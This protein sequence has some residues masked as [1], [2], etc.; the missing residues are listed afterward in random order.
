M[1]GLGLLFG[2]LWVFGGPQSAV[3]AQDG[4]KVSYPRALERLESLVA[5]LNESLQET[6]EE[7]QEVRLGLNQTKKILREV[8]SE[9]EVLKKNN[10]RLEVQ[11]LETRNVSATTKSLHQQ[12]IDELRA[13]QGSSGVKALKRGLKKVRKKVSGLEDEQL[14]ERLTAIENEQLPRQLNEL[15]RDFGALQDEVEMVE[16]ELCEKVQNL[17]FMFEDA[18]ESSEE[19]ITVIKRELARSRSLAATQQKSIER[20]ITQVT[21]QGQ[22][23]NQLNDSVADQGRR[24][25]N[26]TSTVEE[27]GSSIA[28]LKEDVKEIK[29]GE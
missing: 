23:V 22:R 16:N 11:L 10:G 6:K 9:N 21:R 17:T 14:S 28:R 13:A 29:K 26:L 20:L 25:D 8:Q 18:K 4:G 19:S 2:V 1:T 12:A 3:L 15:T 27:Q 24:L 7:L 5:T